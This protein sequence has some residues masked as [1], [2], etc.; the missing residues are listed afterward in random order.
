MTLLVCLKASDCIVMAA[1]SLTTLKG[2]V[3]STTTI[4]VHRLDSH[5]AACGCGLAR[6]NNEDWA[7]I[8]GREKFTRGSEELE[9]ENALTK[10]VDAVD[11]SNHGACKG[12]NVFLVG[13][14][15]EST[16]GFIIHKLTRHND[17]RYFEGPE[18]V[19]PVTDAN[20]IEYLGD[21]DKILS[22]INNFKTNYKAGMSQ[23]DAIDFAVST[24]R[25][26]RDAA[27][28]AGVTTI[29]GDFIYVAVISKDGV[30]F[31]KH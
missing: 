9:L 6:V 20:F 22:E 3:K 16:K 26:G 30:A 18:N 8:I 2:Q 17:F 23:S 5:A 10:A 7:T 14:Y 29:G 15:D 25:Q 28:L 13:V 11:K 4:K 24:L 12:G 1:D 27:L 19:S 21:T 31:S